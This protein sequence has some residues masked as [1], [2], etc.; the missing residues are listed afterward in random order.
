M[1]FVLLRV[2]ILKRSFFSI[3]SGAEAGSSV[4][5]CQQQLLCLNIFFFLSYFLWGF[6]LASRWGVNYFNSLLAP[7]DADRRLP[8][9]GQ[10][11]VLEPEREVWTKLAS[12]LTVQ[13]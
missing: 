5:C 9:P 11:R 7:R 2:L 1:P 6:F 8:L 10:R 13:L 3:L 4:V 12:M